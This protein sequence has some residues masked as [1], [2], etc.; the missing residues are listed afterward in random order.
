MRAGERLSCNLNFAAGADAD[1]WRGSTDRLFSSSELLNQ[2]DGRLGNLIHRRE[3][4][5]VGLVALLGDDHVGELRGE[6]HI[7]FLDGTAGDVAVAGR[8]GLADVGY[9][10]GKARLVIVVPDLR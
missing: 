2:L 4:L 3:H 9:P 5:G 6:V 1:L 8:P 7:R 10:G